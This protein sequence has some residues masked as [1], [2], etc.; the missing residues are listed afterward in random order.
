MRFQEN[1]AINNSDIKTAKNRIGGAS[2]D[3][4]RFLAA[5]FILI[6]HYYDDIPA[7][8]QL[9]EPLM[10]QGWLATNLFMM[11]SGLVMA[12]AYANNFA[13]G[14]INFESFMLK[15]YARLI[16][17]H[18]VVLVVFGLIIFGLTLL[19]YQPHNPKAF[20]LHGWIE[21]LTLVYSWGFEDTPSWNIPTWTISSL[22]VCYAIYALVIGYLKKL[23]IGNL[24]VLLAVILVS[25]N[26]IAHYVFD[27]RM[28]ELSLQFSL[29]RAIPFFMMGVIA[30][31]MTRNL[32]ISKKQYAF[33]AILLFVGIIFFAYENTNSVVNDNAILVL[34]CAFLA[35]SSRVT[36]DENSMT[37]EMGKASYSLFLVHTPIQIIGFRVFKIIEDKLHLHDF[38]LWGIWFMMIVFS[39]AISFV[40]QYYVDK[41]L[42]EVTKKL[43]QKRRKVAMV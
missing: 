38:A 28:V 37:R 9:I 6:F 23:S 17:S 33:W 39:I 24:L 13:E 42:A 40:F 19:G 41:P 7:K 34:T 3:I 14:H 18:A 10:K 15:R 26:F 8:V 12:R 35:I 20:S 32:A 29:G 22:L 2:L 27:R 25:A 36:F 21:Q 31:L 16:P 43:L 4:L 30:E 11:L 5:L 1:K